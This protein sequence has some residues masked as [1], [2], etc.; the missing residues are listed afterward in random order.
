MSSII[1]FMGRATKDPVWQQGKNGADYMNLSFSTTQRN[2]NNEFETIYYQC[3]F[4]KFLA[5]RLEKAS[6]KKGSCLYIYGELD[7]HPFLYQQGEKSGQPG[8]NA[9]VTVK[10]WQYTISNR[11]QNDSENAVQNPENTQPQNHGNY[12]NQRST[13]RSSY[14][15]NGYS[16]PP[17]YGNM[18]PPQSGYNMSAYGSMPTG[19]Y[20]G[21]GFQNIPEGQA[22]HLPFSD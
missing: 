4:N 11:S 15:N 16:A 9:K 1:H 10:D 17:T 20:S 7:L 19:S 3:F 18:Y 21:D 14:G 5:E 22:T 13:N 6:V 2:Q 8:I 12:S